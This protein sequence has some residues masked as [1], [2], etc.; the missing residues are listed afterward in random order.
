MT[1][2]AQFIL[3]ATMQDEMNTLAVGPDWRQQNKDWD[4]AVFTEA[5]ECMNH[6]GWEWWKKPAQNLAQAKMEII[7]MLHFAI[8]GALCSYDSDALYDAIMQ[9]VSEMPSEQTAEMETWDIFR[10][11]K[12]ASLHAVVG[13]FGF[14]LYLCVYAASILGMDADDVFKAYV[15]K[16]ILNKFRKANGYKEGTYIKIWN[17][18][19][20]NEHLTDV[21]NATDVTRLDFVQIIEQQLEAMYQVVKTTQTH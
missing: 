8:S 7:D 5:A 18:R 10:A 15:G 11:L 14:S 6:L 9:A 19:E 20:D 12:E 4:T 21:L 16:N 13:N 3:V 2:K 1:N 17:T